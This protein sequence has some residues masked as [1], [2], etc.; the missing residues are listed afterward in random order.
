[1]KKLILLL[2]LL[3]PLSAAPNPDQT[4]QQFVI[5]DYAPPKLTKSNL[6]NYLRWLR[7]L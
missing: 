7:L 4:P 3:S 1:M 2:A 5:V 6:W